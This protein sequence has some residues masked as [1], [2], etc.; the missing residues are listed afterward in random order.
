[1]ARYL[2]SMV[3]DS[4]GNLWIYGGSFDCGIPNV[5]FQVLADMW[6]YTT[7]SNTWQFISGTLPLTTFAAK[8][9]SFADYG[10]RGEEATTNSP[11][12]RSGHKLTIDLSTN[13]I[14]IVGGGFDLKLA[15][16]FGLDNVWRFSISTGNFTWLYGGSA[17]RF[18]TTNPQ[19]YTVVNANTINFP[20]SMN[21]P[22]S[23]Q[24]GVAHFHSPSKSMIYGFGTSQIRNASSSILSNQLFQLKWACKPGFLWT[25]STCVACAANTYSTGLLLKEGPAATCLACPANSSTNGLLAQTICNVCD[26][27]YEFSGI[28]AAPCQACTPGSFRNSSMSKCKPC[29]AGSF[30]ILSLHCASKSLKNGLQDSFLQRQVHLFAL[31]V[32]AT[33][34]RH[35]NRQYVMYAQLAPTATYCLLVFTAKGALAGKTA[36]PSPLPADVMPVRPDL[37][38][39]AVGPSVKVVTLGFTRQIWLQEH[40][41]RARQVQYRLRIRHHADSVHLT[42][43]QMIQELFVQAAQTTP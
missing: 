13:E 17:G 30:S 24:A 40:A 14:Y 23:F 28:A 42:R 33:R 11:G 37:G 34:T 32:P 25:G 22:G 8:N 6:K 26:L 29:S 12:A 18:L 38:V 5:G 31:L 2:S 21:I 43:T 15:R 27:G 3:A 9:S 16:S 10:I 36:A 7:A 39:L 35:K 20:N 4:T 19:I 1:M 41:S